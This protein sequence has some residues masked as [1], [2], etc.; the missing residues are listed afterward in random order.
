MRTTRN[1]LKSQHRTSSYRG[2]QTGRTHTQTTYPTFNMGSPAFNRA[3]QECQWRMGSYRSIYTQFTG[4]GQKTVF[5]P[6]NANK[7][8]KYVNNGWRVY[9]WNN[10]DFCR[11]FGRQWEYGTP[12]SCFRWMRQRYG[13]GIK[14][15]TRGKG[16]G[17]LVAT[18]PNIT[19][20]PFTTYQWK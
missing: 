11:H 18:T 3:R 19:A 14:A 7:W 9:Y 8:L 5:S 20:R 1:Y 16:N 6:T 4:A 2:T 10:K 17:W 13:T 15:V 12:T